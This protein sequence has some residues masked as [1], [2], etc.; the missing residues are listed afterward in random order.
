MRRGSISLMLR[1]QK[2][3]I[4]PGVTAL[5]TDPHCSSGSG[6]P[7]DAPATPLLPSCQS[8]WSCCA[9]FSLLSQK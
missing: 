9:A 2:A 5:G 7:R 4:C 6:H 8:C 3:Q 1:L